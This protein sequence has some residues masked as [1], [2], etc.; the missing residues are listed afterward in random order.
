MAGKIRVDP[1]L[2]NAT[3]D[4]AKLRAFLAAPKSA[5]EAREAQCVCGA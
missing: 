2:A 3:L 4:M 5:V 1:D